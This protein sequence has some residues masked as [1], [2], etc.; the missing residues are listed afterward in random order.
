MP[1]LTSN[2][3]MLKSGQYS[4]MTSGCGSS[5][6]HVHRAHMCPRS[7][8]FRT[9][10]DGSISRLRLHGLINSSRNFTTWQGIGRK[11]SSTGSRCQS[12][13]MTFIEADFGADEGPRQAIFKEIYVES[14]T[15]KDILK[16]VNLRQTLGHSDRKSCTD[17]RRP[18][19]RH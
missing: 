10:I 13:L 7:A 17:I 16:R 4:D 3:D 11:S 5:E 14:K 12:H 15:R 18:G 9:G 1:S 2:L 19:I 8:V 6:L